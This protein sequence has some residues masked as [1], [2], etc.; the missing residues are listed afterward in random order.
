MT[1]PP[2]TNDEAEARLEVISAA[3]EKAAADLQTLV[4]EINKTLEETARKD[5]YGK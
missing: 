2:E 4:N 1:S 3:L 5:G